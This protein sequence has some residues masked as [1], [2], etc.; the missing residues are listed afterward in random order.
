MKL[1]MRAFYWCRFDIFRRWRNIPVMVME[2]SGGGRE[3]AV[4]VINSRDDED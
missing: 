4:F 3:L 1:E 2:Y